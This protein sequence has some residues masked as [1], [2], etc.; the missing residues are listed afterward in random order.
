MHGNH[1]LHLLSLKNGSKNNG[2]L[3]A[4]PI[5]QKMLWNYEVEQITTLVEGLTIIRTKIPILRRTNFT[6][7]EFRVLNEHRDVMLG[8]RNNP[9][10]ICASCVRTAT[11][12]LYLP[13]KEVEDQRND[14]LEENEVNLI[15]GIVE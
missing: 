15:F 9:P 12:E 4:S 3:P 11:N 6:T 1:L 8:L 14:L 2:P 13:S 7:D 10:E 5:A